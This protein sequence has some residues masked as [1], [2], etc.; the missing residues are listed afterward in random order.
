M[1]KYVQREMFGLQFEY[2]DAQSCTPFGVKGR[3]LELKAGT[4]QVLKE[5]LLESYRE[6][7]RF[8]MMYCPMEC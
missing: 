1:K 5:V 4:A 7:D 8:C 3:I 6:S 2:L